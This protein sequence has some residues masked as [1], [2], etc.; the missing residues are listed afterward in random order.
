MTTE[1]EHLSMDSGPHPEQWREGATCDECRQH[2]SDLYLRLM[3]GS[4][5]MIGPIGRSSTNPKMEEFWATGNPDVFGK[6][7]DE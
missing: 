3:N 5:I 7:G 2:S 4:P 6:K 1:T